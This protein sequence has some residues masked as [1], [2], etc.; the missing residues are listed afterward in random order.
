LAIELR[1]KANVGKIDCT[2]EGALCERFSVRAFPT[3]KL[4]IF[5][6][7]LFFFFFFQSIILI[8]YSSN[9]GTMVDYKDTRSINAFVNFSKRL[10]RLDFLKFNFFNFLF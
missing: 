8:L 10:L 7:F 6:S 1:G 2:E 4:L 3:I 5:F 9:Y